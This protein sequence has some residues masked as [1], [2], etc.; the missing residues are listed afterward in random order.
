MTAGRQADTLAARA[1]LL[2]RRLREIGPEGEL[3]RLIALG[4]RPLGS[5]HGSD[6]QAAAGHGVPPGVAAGH[7]VPPGAAAGHS[8]APAAAR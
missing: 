4:Q 2:A 8:A 3:R 6:F 7:G 5:S 1:A